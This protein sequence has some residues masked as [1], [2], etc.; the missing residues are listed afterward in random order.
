MFC[1]SALDKNDRRLVGDAARQVIGLTIPAKRSVG[2]LN[3]F[4]AA[5]GC[6]HAISD[7]DAEKVWTDSRVCAVCSR[8]LGRKTTSLF[9]HLVPLPAEG[10]HSAENLAVVCGSCARSRGSSADLTW[11][12]GGQDAER[13][14]APYLGGHVYQVGLEDRR[15][16]APVWV[17]LVLGESSWEE[18]LSH[19][20]HS[21]G[22]G[23]RGVAQHSGEAPFGDFRALLVRDSLIAQRVARECQR[24]GDV[25]IVGR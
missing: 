4:A 7:L 22:Q 3:A 11:L 9:T 5:G 10:D 1:L 25:I 13:V 21:I 16:G 6:A 19:I 23:S 17:F 15:G 24:G 12:R 18:R 8:S 20:R 2:E 14:L